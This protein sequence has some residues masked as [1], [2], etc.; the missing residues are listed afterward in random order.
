LRSK[1]DFC[2]T[3]V[4]RP[5]SSVLS[6]KV[7]LKRMLESDGAFVVRRSYALTSVITSDTTGDGGRPE[8][9]GL[10]LWP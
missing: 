3:A 5:A 10:S 8:L 2:I 4:G 7:T 6:L 9:V 1:R